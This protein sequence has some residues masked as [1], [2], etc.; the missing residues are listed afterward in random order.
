[1]RAGE[2]G[3]ILTE[4]DD[5]IVGVRAEAWQDVIGL[6]GD[7]LRMILVNKLIARA[8][9][10]FGGEGGR[11][12]I[13]RPH[14]LVQQCI[15]ALPV[16]A[17]DRIEVQ[18]PQ[19]V[20]AHE[21]KDSLGA[22]FPSLAGTRLLDLGSGNGYLG[23]WLATLG[24]DYVGVEPSADLNKAARSDPRLAGASLFEE[25]IRR[26][27]EGDLYP[28]AEPPTLISII[29][30]IDH[31][32]DPEASLCALFDFLARRNWLNVPVL[33]ATFD[34]DFFL[35]GLPVRDFVRQTSAPYGVEET[36]GIRDPAAWEEIFANSGFHLLEQRPLHISGLPDALAIHLHKLHERHFTGDA[37]ESDWEDEA[38]GKRAAGARVPPRQGPF[39]FWLLCPRNVAV[40]R[41][42][43]PIEGE[44]S[45]EPSQVERFAEEEVLSVI[46]NLGPRVYRL[47]EGEAYFESPEIDQMEFG[48]GALF[49]QL[50][51]SCNY[52]S[53]RMLGTLTARAGACIETVESRQVFGH[54]AGSG[55][56]SDQLFL[57][58]LGHLDSVQFVSFTSAK[59]GDDRRKAVLSGI[60]NNWRSVRNIAACLLQA[61]AAAVP[62]PLSRGYRSRILI[63][64]DERRICDFIYGRDSSRESDKLLNILPE[65]VQAN[66]IDSFSA[67]L[68]EHSGVHDDIDEIGDIDKETFSPLHIGWQ[69]AR[70]IDY[71][72][73]PVDAEGL[74]DDLYPRALAISAFLGL[75]RDRDMFKSEFAGQNGVESRAK[76]AAGG[77]GRAATRAMPKNEDQRC[78][79]VLEMVLGSEEGD[80]LS[81]EERMRSKAERERLRR[82][83]F[84]LRAGF[85]YNE[86]GTF[87]R[88]HGLSSLIVVRDVWAL[89][90]CLL[91]RTDLWKSSV[92][93]VRPSSYMTQR[94]QK[95][96]IIAYIQECI[97]YAGRQ[98]GFD[99]CP[100]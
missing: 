3:E 52:V 12:R 25:T 7:P 13:A 37:L 75:S 64:L 45:P 73:P 16:S 38:G 59:R 32:A 49:G 35:P 9:D 18:M 50:E 91:N 41:Q 21:N 2:A 100:W 54:L 99:G 26:F 22:E 17:T 84:T 1:M 30:V 48:K 80:E 95:P 88:E 33:V 8:L 36:L 19:L 92:R 79:H 87:P 72:F 42:P 58:L 5:V 63:E 23:G 81:Q 98:A 66:V 28:H 29:G 89:I 97:A 39:Y 70:F 43:A 62:G 40:E 67:Y 82:F 24:V 27:C 14:Q 20:A 65:L 69:A 56:F 61:S 83:L 46:G 6:Y 15:A 78:E 76:I 85:N 68:L 44:T 86:K 60:N 10:H 57:S 31:L 93:W 53:S 77:P 47:V 55:R 34:P 51:A 11:N 90:A 71:H 74:A 4:S 94:A 96:R